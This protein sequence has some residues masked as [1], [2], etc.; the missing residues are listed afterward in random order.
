MHI[1]A[2]SRLGQ[3]EIVARLGAGGM[4]EVYRA[5]DTRLGRDVAVKALSA[6]LSLD[7]ARLS[8][9]ETEARSA[10][11]LNH[12][13]IVT[14]HEVGRDAA[15]PFI[16]MELVEGR[17]LRDILYT[18]ALPVRRALNLSAQLADAL[19]RAHEAGIVHRDLKPE[20]IM[21]TRDGFV[22]VLDFGLAK[23]EP[24]GDGNGAGRENLTLTEDGTRE[25]AV[26]GTAGY[27]S[28]E[29]ASGQPVDFRSD[30]FAFG[31]LVYELLSG[32]RAFQRPTRAE[33]LVAII[34]EDP[35]PLSTLCPRIPV[36]LLWIV[37][38]CMAKLPEERYAS[39]RDLAR[40][41]KSVS[42]H[43][44]QI[45][46]GADGAPLLL[47]AEPR[48]PRRWLSGSV[49]LAFAA[50]VASA[51]L[52]GTS[53]RAP[54]LP[55]YHRL[56]FRDGTVWSA[57]FAP[58]GR[59][60]V[61][62][63]AW[64]GGP[65]RA[66]S[67][68][69]ENPESAELP[70]PPANVLAASASGELAILLGARPGG[71]FSTTGTLARSSLA[72]G[73][74]REV[75]E[76]VQGADF[77]PD[78]ASLAVLRTAN[79]RHRLEFPPGRVLYETASGYLSHVR[80]S[81]SGEL[82]AFL[83]HPMRGD[84]AGL[85]AVVDREGHKRVLSAGWITARGLAWSPDGGE[86]WITAAAAGGS[87]ALH[88]VAL[89]G[90]RRLVTR[91]PGS[92]TLHDI[93]REG[94]VLLS[95]EHS[96]EGMVGLSPGELKER[97]LSWHDWSRPVDLTA[98]GTTLL[99]DETGE[100]GGAAFAVY[101]RKTDESPAVRIGEGHALALS[102][103]G[104]W[105]LST[106]QTT[107]AELVLL[108]T[109]AGEPRRIATGAFVHIQ[110]A[111]WLPGAERVVLAA[112]EAERGTRLYVQPASGG[113]PRAITPEGIGPDW[114]VSPDGGGVAAIGPDRSLLLYPIEPGEP[115]PIAGV[116]PG[117]A[118]IRFSPDGRALYV[119]GRGDGPVSSIARID[120]ASGE[121]AAWK[122]IAPADGAGIAGVPRV[123]LS[124]DGESY[125]YSYAR[126]LDE[127]FLVDG[128]R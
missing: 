117:D 102:P 42:D 86:V 7:P 60:V 62:G 70:L 84:D 33:S 118:P 20:N 83:E 79:G 26:V 103:D 73:G 69:P 75:L 93:S 119:R 109:G 13:N 123:F 38:R 43:F 59:T 36:P 67:T 110:R 95:Q 125:V 57:R 96:R 128:L 5:R 40:D 66:Y 28:P 51:Y 113:A 97:D 15:T 72:G 64:N 30:Q 77:A 68:R 90:H 29:Q 106:P 124:A 100:G 2:G 49:A 98:D 3:Y 50:L 16:V 8:R 74:P 63:A 6:E 116:A 92:L 121:R 91:V 115:T 78:G 12:P 108:P 9:F 126:L 22:K 65:I 24:R 39:T 76:A 11:A 80:V 41:L 58:D 127:L 35:E 104:R 122:D 44:S 89:S 107:P 71:P 82:V 46:S 53:A 85:L 31:A 94:R 81:P 32:K 45:D 87:R 101:V 23:I 47:K 88:A 14:I 112:S 105:A 56:T 55:S 54:A 17:T 37:E 34:R 21:V 48:K 111:A 99:F 18:G 61:Y 10:S 27:M 19:A 25:G 4:G 114:A 52:L 120:L 1:S